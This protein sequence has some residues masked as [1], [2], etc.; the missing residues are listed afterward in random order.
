[1]RTQSAA[2]AVRAVKGALYPTLL[3]NGNLNTTYSSAATKDVLLNSTEIS[4]SNYVIVN[5]NKAPVFTKINNY[6]SERIGYQSQIKNNVFSN[7]EL[8]LRVPLFN[9]SQTRNRVRLANLELK[10]V[11]LEEENTKI[12]LRQEV[13]RAYLNMSNAWERYQIIQEQVAAYAESFH[14]AD[15]RFNAGVGT[16]IDYLVAKNN[17]DRANTNLVVAQYEY[18]LRKR[19]L[20]YYYGNSRFVK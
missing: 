3:L 10:N 17:L 14:A 1:L 6:S 13:E 11:S 2:A 16:S 8:S 15:V 4:T 20:D 19:I 9:S 18:I 12:Q 5:G 7:I